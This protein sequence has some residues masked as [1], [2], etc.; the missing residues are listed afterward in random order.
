[1]GVFKECLA[2]LNINYHV[3]SG[4]NHNPMLVERVNRYLNKGL[5][6]MTNEHDSIRIALEG[7]LLLIYAWNSC[8]V[9]GTDISRSLVALGHEFSFPSTSRQVLTPISRPHLVPSPRIHRTLLSALPHVTRSRRCSSASNVVGIA[10]LSMPAIPILAFTLSMTSSLLDAPLG[11]IPSVA[12]WINL[13]TLSQVHG[14]L[15]NHSQVHLTHLNSFRIQNGHRRSMLPTC[16]H[17]HR[18]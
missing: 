18:N 10:N 13:F 3:L 12:R 9:P 17:I 5:R 1:M 7:I 11:P 16:P 6:I 8:P 4:D 14:A 15:P 2:L